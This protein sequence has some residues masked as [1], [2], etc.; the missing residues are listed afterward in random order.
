[1]KKTCSTFILIQLSKISHQYIYSRLQRNNNFSYDR[2]KNPHHVLHCWNQKLNNRKNEVSLVRTEG[3]RTREGEKCE[4]WETTTFLKFQEVDLLLVLTTSIIF[5]VACR[6]SSATH[7][8]SSDSLPHNLLN[9]NST[10]E[11]EKK[12]PI[13]I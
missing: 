2:K 13:D 4:K 7:V 9:E 10:T 5:K 6:F 12:N 3:G 8:W 1:M 11:N